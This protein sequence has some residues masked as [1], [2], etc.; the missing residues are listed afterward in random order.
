MC[1]PCASATSLAYYAHAKVCT[2]MK[3]AG[4]VYGVAGSQITD[5]ETGDSY[6]DPEMARENKLESQMVV[7]LSSSKTDHFLFTAAPLDGYRFMGWRNTD[8]EWLAGADTDILQAIVTTSNYAGSYPSQSTAPEDPHANDP[9]YCDT[10]YIAVFEPAFSFEVKGVWYLVQ[11]G[12]AYV[13]HH[14]DSHYA[15]GKWTN[16]YTGDLVVQPE[17]NFR[18]ETYP[19]VGFRYNA[20]WLPFEDSG[21]T[22]IRLPNTINRLPACSFSGCSNLKKV[23]FDDGGNELLYIRSLAFSNCSSLTDI[24]L[25]ARTKYIGEE[26][27]KNCASLEMLTIPSRCDTLGNSIISNCSKLKTLVMRQSKPPVMQTLAGNNV[28]NHLKIYSSPAAYA[29][30]RSADG[31][32]NL[33]P[34]HNYVY[35]RPTGNG[36]FGTASFGS[37]SRPLLNNIEGVKAYHTSQQIKDGKLVIHSIGYAYSN[38][39]FMGD[40]II[41][42]VEKPQTVYLCP[43]K[44]NTD[45]WEQTDDSWLIP[46]GSSGYIYPSDDENMTYYHLDAIDGVWVK[47]STSALVGRCQC[48]LAVPQKSSEL[49]GVLEMVLEDGSD[50]FGIRG[51]INGDGV[52]DVTDVSIA[53]D[54][55]LGKDSNDNY[56][57][58]AD[59]DGNGGVDV[60]DVSLIIDIVLGK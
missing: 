59:L 7:H 36:T 47:I 54:I 8:G 27:F 19:V 21:I 60:T 55:V 49:P 2:N 25:P 17:V 40:G 23:S 22:S 53:I 34:D 56:G 35:L 29:Y 31:W 52:V 45:I 5:P 24:E 14:P 4:Y 30:Y 15:D 38:D 18:G 41:Y 46:N 58:A 3:G 11:D 32:K 28:L 13:A 1:T 37:Y 48:Y 16:A 44:V 10:T 50:P 42:K 51:D 33:Y 20:E 26:A 6:I 39:K 9:N 43:Q 12:K 57:G